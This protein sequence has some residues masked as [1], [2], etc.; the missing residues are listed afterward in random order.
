MAQIRIV[1]WCDTDLT[2]ERFND[3]HAELMEEAA[4]DIGEDVSDA[5]D[6]FHML[7]QRVEMTYHEVE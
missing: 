1:M 4:K 7:L 3:V 2:P 5:R 6:D